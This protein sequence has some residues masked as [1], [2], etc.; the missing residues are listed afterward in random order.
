[1]IIAKFQCNT[2]A[3]SV[4]QDERVMLNAV[5]ADS[6]PNK[7]W[8]KYTPSGSLD[9]TISNPSAQGQIKPGKFYKITIEEAPEGF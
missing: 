1:M 3:Q 7:E 5:Y 9:M 4:S 6:G 8:A 2:V